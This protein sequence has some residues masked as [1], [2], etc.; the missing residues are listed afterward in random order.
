MAF[1]DDRR[2]NTYLDDRYN[3]G[4]C[5]VRANLPAGRQVSGGELQLLVY[6]RA[7]AA[8][9]DPIEKKP[10]YHFLPGSKIFSIGTVGCN[11]GCDFCQ[12]ADIS[13]ITKVLQSS[14]VSS[15]AADK[16]A[17]RSQKEVASLSLATT[18]AKLGYKLPPKKIVEYCVEEKIPSIAFTYNEPTIFSEYAVD[19]MKLAKKKRIYGV[20]VSNGFFTKEC[21]D[22]IAPHIGAFNIDLKSF[23][24]DYYRKI[25]K[26]RLE[27]VLD[28]IKRVHKAKKH[29]EITTLVVPGKNDSKKE[30]AQIA[31]FIAGVSKDIPWHISAFYPTYKM[32]D[33]VPT[34]EEKLFE[35]YE[36]GKKAG[37][38]YVYTGNIADMRLSQTICPK[39]SFTVIARNGYDTSSRLKSGLCP[40]C[41]HKVY[42]IF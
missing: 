38:N 1:D 29:L 3:T 11:F 21:F 22:F 40:N 26:A 31:K 17:R 25:C 18:C 37:L 6:G 35:A 15:R 16:A 30:L 8:N 36:I 23:S 19:V 20:Y 2:Q 12:N 4:I 24:D 14:H 34:P 27:P 41:E 33:N 28:S 39:C 42:G 32:T 13:Q 5:G 7:I 10:L 9:I